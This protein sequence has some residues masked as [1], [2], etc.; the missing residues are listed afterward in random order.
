MRFCLT[1]RWDIIENQTSSSRESGS[2]P[3]RT[4]TPSSPT[5]VPITLVRVMSPIIGRENRTRFII[6]RLAPRATPAPTRTREA[7][8]VFLFSNILLISILNHTHIQFFRQQTP[9]TVRTAPTS[10][11]A[12]ASL[13]RTGMVKLNAGRNP[14]TFCAGVSSKCKPPT[15]EANAHSIFPFSVFI[16]LHILSIILFTSIFNFT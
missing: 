15:V 13:P 16:Q 6:R 2:N 11:C 7:P 9:Q 1:S 8:I 10:C 5:T 14:S 4:A 12:P 3:V